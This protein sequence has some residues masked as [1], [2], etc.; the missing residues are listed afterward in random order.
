MKDKWKIYPVTKEC[1]ELH[2]LGDYVISNWRSYFIVSYRPE[3]WHE[4]VGQY[5]TLEKAKYA[6]ENHKPKNFGVDEGK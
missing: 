5:S 4:H 2:V 3:G 6:A 1:S